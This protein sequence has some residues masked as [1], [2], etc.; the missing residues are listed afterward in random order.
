[1]NRP[2]GLVLIRE[3]FMTSKGVPR[4]KNV[5]VMPF[6]AKTRRLPIERLDNKEP[7]GLG[8][9]LEA[10]K[11]LLLEKLERPPEG[12]TI[13]AICEGYLAEQWTLLRSGDEL[14]LS[15]STL[16]DYEVCL[17]TKVIP[18]LGHMRPC[19]FERADAA[20]YLM[21][22][23]L[24][25]RAVRA[26]R[27]MAAL[28]SAFSY[29]VRMRLCRENP[30]RGVPRNKE[31]PRQRRVS[32]AELNAFL[33]HA[34]AQGGSADMVALIGCT[35]ALTGRRRAEVL[36]LPKSAATAEGIR[37]KD[38]KTKAGEA[39]RSY[40]VGWSPIL[41]QVFEEVLAIQR[42]I[43]SVYLFPTLDGQ[44]Y[45]D[46]G[47]KCLWN[48]LMHSHAPG[49]AKLA[50]WFRAHDLRALYVS[51]MLEQK[52]DPHTHANEETMRR[53]YD[54]RREIKITPLA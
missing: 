21:R 24:L 7:V 10:A 48:R 35:V 14:A 38:A 27:E 20:K 9:D 40:L 25:K 11:R 16:R 54:R 50:D 22:N 36:T 28:S 47:F 45:T 52:R 41:R 15:E 1:M 33:Q 43:S 49:G 32:V 6:E 17:R 31:K 53:V 2:I 5:I 39:A 19:E 44:Q 8:H 46:K 23:R 18:V 37:M 13:A 42:R 12:N 51:E 34:K 26:N 29:G 3:E 30:C 4:W